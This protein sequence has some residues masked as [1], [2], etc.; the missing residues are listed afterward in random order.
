[1]DSCKCGL[2]KSV[3]HEAQIGRNNHTI[4]KLRRKM[5]HN[6]IKDRVLRLMNDNL[7]MMKCVGL[8]S[9]HYQLRVTEYANKPK[10]RGKRH[11]GPKKINPGQASPKPEFFKAKKGYVKSRN[12]EIREMRRKRSRKA[13]RRRELKKSLVKWV[14]FNERDEEE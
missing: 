12:A 11:Y 10:L 1:M 5:P 9:E 6:E 13:M 7:M 14:E 8:E 4:Q 2:G 3:D